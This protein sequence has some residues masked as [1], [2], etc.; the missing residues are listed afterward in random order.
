MVSQTQTIHFQLFLKMFSQSKAISCLI[1]GN[2]IQSICYVP[3]GPYSDAKIETQDTL[4]F[5]VAM[6]SVQRMVRLTSYLEA[7]GLGL[8]WS[9]LGKRNVVWK[10]IAD[11]CLGFKKSEEK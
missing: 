5:S 8:L 9:G 3:L 7:Q 10:K 2:Q 4:P 11:F 6:G 1:P